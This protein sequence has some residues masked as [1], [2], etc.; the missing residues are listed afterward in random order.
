MYFG[1]LQA[2]GW[3]HPTVTHTPLLIP[4]RTTPWLLESPVS[5][6]SRWNP[7]RVSIILVTL[8]YFVEFFVDPSDSFLII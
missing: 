5:Q 2:P 3:W 6:E 8:S 4:A 1:A 7:P